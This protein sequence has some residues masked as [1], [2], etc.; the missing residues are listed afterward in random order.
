MKMKLMHKDY[1]A[2]QQLDV[3]REKVVDAR[4]A[5]A[6]KVKALTTLWRAY[7]KM[8]LDFGNIDFTGLYSLICSYRIR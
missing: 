3:K 7:K 4:L 8:L 6:G 5:A 1:A 2:L